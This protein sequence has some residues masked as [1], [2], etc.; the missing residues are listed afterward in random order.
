VH[1]LMDTDAP[2]P[3][4]CAWP[5]NRQWVYSITF[6]EALSDLHRFAIP[7]LESYGVPGHVEVVVGQLGQVRN[8]G[9]SSFDGFQHMGA[10]EL[11][12]LVARGWGVG[13]HSWSHKAVNAET[14]AQELG[15]AK[16][17]LSEACG[18]PVTVYC[19]PGSNA[20]M[21]DGALDGCRRY[22]YLGAMGITDALNRPDDA[23]LLW[24]N[25]TFLHHQG[26]GP[27]FSEFDPFRNVQH[28]Q[29]D[30]GWII[31]YLHC[32]LEQPVH[33]NK[34]CSQAQLRERIETIVTE[35]GD[36]VWLTP[37]EAPVEYRYVR[38]HT[39]IEPA[40]DGERGTYV[41]SAPGVPEQVRRRTVTLALPRDTRAAEVDGTRAQVYWKAG[42]A[43]LDVNVSTNRRVRLFGAH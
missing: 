43:L 7:I 31:D 16:E 1:L 17:V 42:T 14:A 9:G 12:D 18:Q 8:L 19:A 39:H 25:R 29:R 21:N 20:N 30:R 40:G 13:N 4:I 6:D 41:V 32:P 5:G 22:G 11:R 37:V 23:D 36:D 10:E 15:R 33:P 38:R 2:A 35:G 34:D 3:V 28:A 27:F 24:L 26:Y